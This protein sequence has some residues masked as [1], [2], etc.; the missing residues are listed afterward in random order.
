[1]PQRD[2]NCPLN[3]EHPDVKDLQKNKDQIL[4]MFLLHPESFRNFELLHHLHDPSPK[5]ENRVIDDRAKRLPTM[6]C[7]GKETMS[8]CNTASEINNMN[9]CRTEASNVDTDCFFGGSLSQKKSK[10]T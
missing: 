9:S 8:C 7:K 1:M 4:E 10:G 2:K 5:K 3:K 6:A